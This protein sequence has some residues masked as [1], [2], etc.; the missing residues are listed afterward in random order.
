[1]SEGELKALI[2]L[3]DDSDAE[4]STLVEQKIISLGDE[5]IPFLV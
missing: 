2:S 5:I 1:M 3:L 4:V